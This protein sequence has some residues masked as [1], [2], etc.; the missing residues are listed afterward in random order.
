MAGPKTAVVLV[1]AAGD[2]NIGAAARAMKNFGLS[3]LRLVSCCPH[4]TKAAYMYA[5]DARDLLESARPFSTLDEALS[6]RSLAVAFTRRAGKMRRR[7]M[8]VSEL[9]GWVAK[10]GGLALVFGREDKGLTNDEVR[11]CDAVVAIPSSPALPSLNLAQS[12]LVAAYELF[13]ARGK[14][15]ART[16]A[17]KNAK[18]EF[19][20]RR[21]VARVM[22]RIGSALSALG[23]ED[24]PSSALKSKILHQLERIFGR[25]GLTARDL[26]MLKGLSA[27]I[28]GAKKSAA[29]A[30]KRRGRQ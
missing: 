13:G 27:R 30:P 22:K 10:R 3:D 12:V 5:V 17:E 23:Y 19:V 4:L 9:P 14:K 7:R 15:G 24:E 26:G 29:P 1:G 11:R 2:A 16:A 25:A 28:G 8:T 18:E 20:S 21:E 6:D